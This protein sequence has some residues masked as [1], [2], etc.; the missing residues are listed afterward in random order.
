MV[1]DG[2]IARGVPLVVAALRATV[3]APFLSITTQDI[4]AVRLAVG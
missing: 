2:P 3:A 4:F 1:I